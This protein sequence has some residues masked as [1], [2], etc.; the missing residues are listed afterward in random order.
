VCDLE[1][2]RG[3]SHDGVSLIEGE[4]LEFRGLSHRGCGIQK[5]WGLSRKGR[6]REPA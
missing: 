4:A 2:F 5:F 3:L 6:C 1:N